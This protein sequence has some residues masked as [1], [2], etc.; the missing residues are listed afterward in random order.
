MR[1]F[2]KKSSFSQTSIMS[3]CCPN[4]RE[5]ILRINIF[6]MI[7]FLTFSNSLMKTISNQNKYRKY[8]MCNNN[9][10]LNFLK[11]NIIM[12]N[13]IVNMKRIIVKNNSQII[14]LILIWRVCPISLPFKKI[15]ILI[16]LQIKTIYLNKIFNKIINF[17]K[18]SIKNLKFKIK[19]LN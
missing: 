13:K 5:V 1:L 2:N 12:S 17:K 18:K 3:S 11:S 19:K 8:S 9:P 10:K 16:L 7:L 6:W 4:K 14:S 15:R